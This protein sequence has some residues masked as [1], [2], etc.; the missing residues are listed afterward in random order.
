[1][2]LCFISNKLYWQHFSIYKDNSYCNNKLYIEIVPDIHL[3]M[4]RSIN[5]FYNQPIQFNLL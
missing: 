4:K 5:K 2:T 1:M 3:L